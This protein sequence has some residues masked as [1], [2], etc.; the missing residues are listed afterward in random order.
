MG[1]DAAYMF[2]YIT[3][4]FIKGSEAKIVAWLFSQLKKSDAVIKNVRRKFLCWFSS[5]FYNTHWAE[6]LLSF[7]PAEK[8]GSQPRATNC[9]NA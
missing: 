9:Q 2:V 8:H 4:G 6:R 3:H 5:Q 1:V 7:N